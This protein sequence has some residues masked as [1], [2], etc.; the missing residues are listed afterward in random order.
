MGRV[1]HVDK[2]TQ[3]KNGVVGPRKKR[4]VQYEYPTGAK[5]RAG[6]RQSLFLAHGLSPNKKVGDSIKISVCRLLPEMTCPRR[7][8]FE[9]GILLVW[10]TF[11]LAGALVAYTE[12][13]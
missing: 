7:P 1:T 5:Q 2:W 8:A 9:F 4:R 11:L 3:A 6:T 10:V 13:G 12:F